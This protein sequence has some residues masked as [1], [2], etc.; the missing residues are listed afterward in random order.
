MCFAYSDVQL[1]PAEYINEAHNQQPQSF[2]AQSE[3][4][5]QKAWITEFNTETI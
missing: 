5:D 1:V 4:I 3:E 2:L